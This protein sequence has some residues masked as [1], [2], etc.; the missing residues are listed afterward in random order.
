[1]VRRVCRRVDDVP[2]LLSD[3]AA[4][5]ICVLR[6]DGPQDAA[7]RAGQAAH[8]AARRVARRAADHS[9]RA[10]EARRQRESVMADPRNADRHDRSSLF[11]PFDH[12]PAGAGVVCPGASGQKPVPAV[13]AVESRLDAGAARLPV[14]GR[15]TRPDARSGDRLVAGLRAVRRAVRR[16]RLGEP[17]RTAGGAGCYSFQQPRNRGHRGGRRAAADRLPTASVVRACRDRVAAAA[18]RVQSH[19]AEHRRRAALVDRAAHDLPDHVHPLLRQLAVV[20]APDLPGHGRRGP[21][22]DGMD[23]GRSEAHP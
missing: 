5:G 16:C 14:R 22:G 3:R 15:A 18:R 8:R 19:H 13:R 1:M 4:R 7:T 12:E 2:R 6:P 23:V 21:R 9:G 11:P 20:P 10:L 17:A